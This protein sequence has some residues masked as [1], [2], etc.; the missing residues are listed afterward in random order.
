MKS[1]ALQSMSIDE[2]WSL[3]EQVTSVLARRILEEKAKLEARLRRLDV[4]IDPNESEPARHR[5]RRFQN[6]DPMMFPPIIGGDHPRPADPTGQAGNERQ[7]VHY[8]VWRLSSANSNEGTIEGASNCSRSSKRRSNAANR[9]D[10][11]SAVAFSRW[12]S[13]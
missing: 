13:W 6:V 1:D 12:P 2:L 9:A 8:T 10:G 3:H 5:A 11:S 7:T 4:A